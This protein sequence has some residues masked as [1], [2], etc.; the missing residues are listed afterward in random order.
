MYTFGIELNL[1]RFEI[2]ILLFRL[3]NISLNTHSDRQGSIFHNIRV[4]VMFIIL[5]WKEEGRSTG[6]TFNAIKINESQNIP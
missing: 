3:M 5:R 2:K 4:D 6:L 1:L